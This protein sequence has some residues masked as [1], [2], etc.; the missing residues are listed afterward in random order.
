MAATERLVDACARYAQREREYLRESSRSWF[1][2]RTASPWEAGVV[3][4]GFTRFWRD[5]LEDWTRLAADVLRR[6]RLPESRGEVEDMRQELAIGALKAF[7]RFAPGHGVDLPAY[8]L[9]NALAYAKKRL[10]K[11]R[12]AKLSGNSGKHPSRIEVTFGALRANNPGEEGTHEAV[13]DAVMHAR[14]MSVEPAQGE[15]IEREERREEVRQVCDNGVESGLV[16]VIFDGF[17]LDVAARRLY[18]DP[19]QRLAYRLGCEGE[20]RRLVGRAAAA[21]VVWAEEEMVA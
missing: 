4:P 17:G 18:E 10:H 20:A 8:V 13:V 1:R 7:R 14:G 21:L 19:D 6:W 15:R 3:K 12:G 2:G 9:W 16:E 11:L 5:T